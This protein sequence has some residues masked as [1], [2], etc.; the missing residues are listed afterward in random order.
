ML[1]VPL[2]RNLLSKTYFPKS[3]YQTFE[4]GVD[5]SL[6]RR[7]GS[8]GETVTVFFQTQLKVNASSIKFKSGYSTGIAEYVYVKQQYNNILFANAVTNVAFKNGKVVSFG[9]LFIQPSKNTLS[10]PSV[11]VDSVV[12]TAEKVL[13]RTYNNHPTSLEY[14]VQLDSS[15]ALTHI[16]QVQNR[17]A[18]TSYEAFVDVHSGRFISSIDF[19]S[20]AVYRVLPMFKQD[21]TEG[22]ELLQDPQDTTSSPLGWHN[23]STF[24]STDTSGNNAIVY[25]DATLSATTSESALGLIFNYTQDPTISLSTQ[26]NLDT[27]RT[28]MFYIVNTMHDLAFTE[29]ALN[30]QQTNVNGAGGVGGDRVLAG[31]SGQMNMYLWDLT[32]PMRDGAL[33]NDIVVHEIMTHGITNRITGGGTGRCL[34]IVESQGLGVMPWPIASP[35][36]DFILGSYVDGGVP[37]RSLTPPIR[38][39]WYVRPQ[40]P[41][42]RGALISP[43][44]LSDVGEVWAN[45]LHNVH[46]ELVSAHGFSKTARTDPTG[47]QGNV[48]FLHLFIDALA[49]QPCQPDFLQARDAIIQADQNRYGG[50]NKCLLWKVFASR[51][52]GIGA[53][54]YTDNFGVPKGC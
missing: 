16:I 23:D 25:F 46:A 33:E 54:D 15:V 38:H 53:V 41:R 37:I 3:S 51:G 49:L 39:A 45:M 29:A 52:L 47:S 44:Q 6:S 40:N 36:T 13:G 31:Q 27:T 34:E 19:V 42:L 32:D 5:H 7:D 18:N 8:L 1:V 10:T 17:T 24:T 11:P 14:L 4:S 48:V 12:L 26:A 28:N 22:F 21:L 30:F 35:I 9:N 50:A 43:C 20:K 2:V